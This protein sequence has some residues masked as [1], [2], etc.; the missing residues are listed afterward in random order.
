MLASRSKII[1]A[2]KCHDVLM[3]NFVKSDENEDD[4]SRDESIYGYLQIYYLSKLFT[5][6]IGNLCIP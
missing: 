5:D 1:C 4:D 2:G 6:V 3:E